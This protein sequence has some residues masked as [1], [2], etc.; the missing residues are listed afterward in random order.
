VLHNKKNNMVTIRSAQTDDIGGIEEVAR[1]TWNATYAEI[2]SPESQERLLDNFY[3]SAALKE[4]V[5]Q[6]GS[7]FFVAVEE[8]DVIGFAQFIVQ[9]NGDGQLTRIYVQPK[10]QRQGIGKEMLKEGLSLIETQGIQRVLVHVEKE[11]QIGIQFYRKR[12]FDYERKFSVDLL[13]ETLVLCEYVI[14][15]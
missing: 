13:G 14:T 15:L 11:N 6:E 8:N 3:S 12:G 1:Q 5:Q 2:I 7:W 4:A 9:E 10:M